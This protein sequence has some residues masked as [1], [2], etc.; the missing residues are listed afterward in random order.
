MKNREYQM[1]LAVIQ[2]KRQLIKEDIQRTLGTLDPRNIDER[3]DLAIAAGC[4]AT[5]IR[6]S[7]CLTV[8]YQNPDSEYIYVVTTNRKR[9]RRDLIIDTAT[10]TVIQGGGIR[11]SQRRDGSNI[12]FSKDTQ[13]HRLLVSAKEDMDADHLFTNVYILTD[14]AVRECHAYQN[15][16]NSDIKIKE[17]KSKS[18]KRFFFIDRACCQEA[19]LVEA[20]KEKEYTFTPGGYID[21]KFPIYEVKSPDF[22]TKEEWYAAINEYENAM[23]G[24][25]RYNPV[26]NLSNSFDLFF[27]CV[28]LQKISEKRMWEIRLQSFLATGRYHETKGVDLKKY[29]NL[30]SQ[31]RPVMVN[32]QFH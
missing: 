10:Y 23:Y 3:I 9:E 30:R 22:D 17:I 26:Q 28:I 15:Q 27:D 16:F 19:A 25:F 21:E 5:T 1:A 29:F 7:G 31:D 18:N 12:A 24:E 2:I 8:F 11:W 4:G 13:I 32:A 14:D 6:S 20:F